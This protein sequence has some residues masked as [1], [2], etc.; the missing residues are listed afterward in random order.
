MIEWVKT[1]GQFDRPSVSKIS[2]EIRE[3]WFASHCALCKIL[4]CDKCPIFLIYGIV[5][6]DKESNWYKLSVAFTW[7]EWLVHA[8]AM[9]DQLEKLEEKYRE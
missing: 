3:N 7:R 4:Y 2:C 5:C 9:L 1:Q 8:G 6:D